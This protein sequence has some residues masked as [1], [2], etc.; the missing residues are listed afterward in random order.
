MIADGVNFVVIQ[1]GAFDEVIKGVD[2]IEHTSSPVTF[3]LDDP[4]GAIV[5]FLRWLSFS[6]AAR[7]QGRN[8]DLRS[9]NQRQTKKNDNDGPVNHVVPSPVDPPVP[10]KLV[11]VEQ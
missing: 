4:G 8:H 7:E 1:E 9:Q 11:I 10:E 3:N 5:S 6:V 2:A